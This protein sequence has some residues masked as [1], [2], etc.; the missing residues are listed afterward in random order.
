[1]NTSFFRAGMRSRL[2]LVT[3]LLLGW[4]CLGG[5]PAAPE[6]PPLTEVS[7]SPRLPGKFVWADLVTD[8]AAAARAFYGGVFQWSFR[9]AGGYLIAYNQD[10]PLAG[11]F[12][13]ARPADKPDAHPRW[14]GYISVPNVTKAERAATAAGGRVLAFDP[15]GW[16]TEPASAVVLAEA[17]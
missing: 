2:A 17:A 13:R 10:R 14:F 11:V 6:L 3:G 15:N 5:G 1:M 16:P 8:D 7:G 12:Q 9:Q 4:T